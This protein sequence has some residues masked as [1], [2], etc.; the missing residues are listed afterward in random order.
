[1]TKLNLSDIVALAKS[2]YSVSDVKELISLSSSDDAHQEQEEKP[3][4]EKEAQP[5]ESGKEPPQET[6]PKKS[7]EDPAQDASAIDEYKK[8]IEKLKE[9]INNLQKENVNKD[10][11]G[12]D[13]GK[14]DEEIL[15][16]ITRSFM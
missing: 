1:M 3:K 6:D 11:S 2:G 9:Q 10:I 16:D 4:D 12:N 13:K 14:S 15:N 8:E 5:Q 7:T